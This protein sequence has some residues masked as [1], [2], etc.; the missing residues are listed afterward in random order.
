MS[1]TKTGKANSKRPIKTVLE[2]DHK[3]ARAYFLEPANYCSIDLPPYFQFDELLR[4]VARILAK[5]KLADFQHERPCDHEN[6]NH[7][8]YNNKDGKYAWRPL[9]I[10]HPAIYVALVNEITSRVNWSTICGRFADF[11]SNDKIACLSIP[12]KSETAQSNKAEQ[13]SHWWQNVEQASIALSLEYDYTIHTDIVDCY[14]AI[15]THSISW[16]LHTKAIAKEP[17]NRSTNALVGNVIDKH[18]RDM[19]Y[20]QT[21]GIPQGS[22]LM[23]FISEM[24]LGYADLEISDRVDKSGILDYRVLRYR[25]DYR[26]F[27]NSSQDGERILK[28]ITEVM[29][30]LGLKLGGGKTKLSNSVVVAS[31]K[32]DKVSWLCRRQE[33]KDLQK[34]L[35]IIHNHSLAYPNS[36]SLITAMSLFHRRIVRI[37][38]IRDAMPIIGILADIAF[39]NPRT[40]P[41]FAAILSHLLLSLANKKT[42]M[43]VVYKIKKKFEKLPNTG[44]MQLWLQRISFPINKGIE[45]DEALCKLVR[46]EPSTIWNNDWISSTELRKALKTDQIVDRDKLAKLKPA[47][48]VKEM[49]LF[50]AR[51]DY[52]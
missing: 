25:D 9:Q 52:E 42:A 28:C 7:S 3:E 26:V 32:E 22:V 1:A 4:N 38:R 15:Y 13:V 49:E 37:K 31:L 20:G 50:L 29:I 30:D 23:D 34:Q 35:L 11:Q 41:L 8:L 46:D 21:N 2:M 33:S 24:V 43:D 5:K 12:V 39:H 16:A 47:V 6:V 48:P 44:H 19:R 17:S 27:T 10:I 14:G 51:D 18:I 36:G 40:Y 45:Y